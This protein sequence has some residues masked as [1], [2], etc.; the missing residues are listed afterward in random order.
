MLET[1]THIIYAFCVLSNP[2]NFNIYY[3]CIFQQCICVLLMYV[4][5]HTYTQITY[6]LA[7]DTLQH[8][9]YMA[10]TNTHKDRRTWILACLS[11]RSSSFLAL[12]S[13]FRWNLLPHT[14]Y[15]LAKKRMLFKIVRIG[16][17]FQSLAIKVLILKSHFMN[18]CTKQ[19]GGGYLTV[20][21]VPL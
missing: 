15:V 19:T 9:W 20:A 10:M 17:L 13:I 3:L 1:I 4:S 8:L 2:Y 16:H 7:Y 18:N 6:V 21:R 5:L 11:A 14:L 12:F